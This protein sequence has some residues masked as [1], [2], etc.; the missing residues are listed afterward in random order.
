MAASSTSPPPAGRPHWCGP[1][2]RSCGGQSTVELA[3][4]LPVL[5]IVTLL[6]IQAALLARDRIALTHRCGVAARHAM[7]RPDAA[8]VTAAGAS[9]AEG[10][11]G[12]SAEL[13]GSRS[14]GSLVTVT[15]HQR[16]VTGLPLV[17]PML[18]DPEVVERLVIRV[19]SLGG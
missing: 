7:V 5:V 8:A 9:A 2:R 6:V 14:V 13:S 4:L 19:E 11:S 1:H 3:A 18:G 12:F 10:G 17:G 15:C 16:L